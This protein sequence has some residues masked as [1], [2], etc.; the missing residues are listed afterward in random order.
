MDPHTVTTHERPWLL[1]FALPPSAGFDPVARF[2]GVPPRCKKGPSSELGHRLREERLCLRRG[3]GALHPG[4]RSPDGVTRGMGRSLQPLPAPGRAQQPA[5]TAS[6]GTVPCCRGF[7]QSAELRR[8]TGSWRWR[9]D[10]L[11]DSAG[12][13]QRSPP[14]ARRSLPASR[15]AKPSRRLIPPCPLSLVLYCEGVCL[16]RSYWQS[17]LT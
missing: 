10:R 13:R 9:R 4:V 5:L 11:G 8:G 2:Q 14:C 15:L 3:L 12:T 16:L 6:F 7:P 1:L 17:G